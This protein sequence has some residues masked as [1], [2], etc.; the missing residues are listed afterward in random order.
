MQL[1]KMPVCKTPSCV[2]TNQE[3]YV[4]TDGKLTIGICYACGSF[5][6]A[7]TDKDILEE[8]IY[9]PELILDLIQSGQL[10]AIN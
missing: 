1:E 9:Q 10:V 4:Y 5:D 7:G 3:L 8:F 6:G 2:R